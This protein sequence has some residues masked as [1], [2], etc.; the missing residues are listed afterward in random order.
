MMVILTLKVQTNANVV[1]N[2]VELT[3]RK[4][5]IV[6]QVS[7][8]IEVMREHKPDLSEIGY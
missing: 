3:V 5:L 1:L 7:V 2:L 8:F 6:A 4:L